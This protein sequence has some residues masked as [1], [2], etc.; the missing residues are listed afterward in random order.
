M[1]TLLALF[2]AAASQ[3]SVAQ[4]LSVKTENAASEASLTIKVTNKDAAADAL[5]RKAEE[6]GGY[7]SER[8]EQALVL[9][10]PTG[11]EGDLI[12][13]GETQG[14][15]IERRFQKA[16]LSE[17]LDQAKSQLRSREE[18]LKRYMDVLRD[19]GADQIVMVE[20]EIVAQIQDIE[21]LK[22]RIRAFEHRLRFA[23]VNVAF[24]FRERR[25]PLK[26]GQSSFAWLNRVNLADLL[27]E[28]RHEN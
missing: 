25:A 27:E 12:A 20:R 6:L 19:A 24:Q 7:F 5:V 14:I 9:R 28:F 3:P 13:L 11:R 22:G 26:T 1:S 15:V 10:V 16:D 23:L 4:A 18:T 8:T 21:R 2:I 17:T